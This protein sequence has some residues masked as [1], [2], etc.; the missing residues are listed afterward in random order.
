MPFQTG[1]RYRRPLQGVAK[2]N[3]FE[4]P[5]K[6]F[7]AGYGIREAIQGGRIAENAGRCRNVQSIGGNRCEKGL[8]V[9]RV[10]PG[11]SLFFKGPA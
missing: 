3:V 1:P 11:Q 4:D 6:L 5:E 7:Q 10:W 8:V 2:L 9:V